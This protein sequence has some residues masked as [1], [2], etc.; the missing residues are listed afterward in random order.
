MPGT[1]H[2]DARLGPDHL[3][4]AGSNSHEYDRNTDE[5]GDELQIV[6]GRCRQIAL[7]AALAQVLGPPGELEVLAGGVVQHRLVVGEVIEFR[8]LGAAIP[9]T[10]GDPIE[11]G[12]HIELGY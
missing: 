3:V 9:G 6:S 10:N 8:A 12:E 5:L 2:P 4:P 11:A 7:R 1:G